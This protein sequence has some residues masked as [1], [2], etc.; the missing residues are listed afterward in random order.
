MVKLQNSWDNLLEEEF[1]KDYYKKLR[2]FLKNEY[3]VAFKRGRK[4]YW[5]ASLHFAENF[6]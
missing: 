4:T 3:I 1:Q 5:I 6:M 2:E